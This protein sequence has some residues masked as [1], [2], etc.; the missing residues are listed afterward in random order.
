MVGC[1]VVFYSYRSRLSC[2]PLPLY[3]DNKTT[4]PQAQVNKTTD[5]TDN[6][7]L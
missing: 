1:Q 2:C 7:G 4:A 3:P 5:N 6:L